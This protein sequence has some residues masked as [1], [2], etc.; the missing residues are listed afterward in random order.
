MANW[1]TFVFSMR[2]A[3]KSN[4]LLLITK[5]LVLIKADRYSDP[6][7]RTTELQRMLKAE[8]Q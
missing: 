7:Q 5:L 4:C 2:L 6:N 3:T 1:G 8:S